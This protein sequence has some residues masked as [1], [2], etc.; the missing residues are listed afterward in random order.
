MVQT[1]RHLSELIGRGRDIIM[2]LGS[3]VRRRL[4]RSPPAPRNSIKDERKRAFV[5]NFP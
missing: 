5:R 4:A 3:G 1:Q 2:S